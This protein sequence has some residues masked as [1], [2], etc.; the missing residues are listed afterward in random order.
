VG[1][2]S[3]FSPLPPPLPPPE[4]LVPVLPLLPLLEDMMS[5]RRVDY[6]DWWMMIINILL[7]VSSCAWLV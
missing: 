5:M 6:G 3:G 4:L 2:G 7:F 1:F